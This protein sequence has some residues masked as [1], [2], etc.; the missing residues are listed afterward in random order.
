MIIIVVSCASCGWRLAHSVSSQQPMHI[1]IP[2]AKGDSTGE[3][4]NRLIAAVS[5]Q[6]GFVVDDSGQ[7]Q[8]SVNL[9]DSREERIGYRYDPRR[10]HEGR[11]KIVP[12]ENRGKQLVEVSIIDTH[13]QKVVRGPVYILGSAE[14]DHQENSIDNDINDFSLGQL[15]DINAAQ[16]VT[17][18]P[19]Y[20]DLVLKIGRWLQNQQDLQA[21]AS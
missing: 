11:K 9:L 14:Y 21:S 13:S 17:Y 4:S 7:Y 10:L 3:F 20:R 18:I 16:D 6:P 1:A 2:Y 5:S 12:N 19:L 8:L 15:S